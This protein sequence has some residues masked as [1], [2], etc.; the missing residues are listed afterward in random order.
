MLKRRVVILLCL[1]DGVLMRTKKFVP[2]YRY[3]VNLVGNR[4]ADEVVVI[5]VTPAERRAEQRHLFY[6]ALERYAAECFSP[7]TVGGGIRTVE[8]VRQLITL[9]AD[10]VVIGC[11]HLPTL[12]HYIARKFGGQALVAAIN[13]AESEDV[14]FMAHW[15]ASHGA[16]EILLN[17]RPRDG[18][19]LGYDL[20]VLARVRPQVTVPIMVAGGCGTWAHIADAFEAGADAACTSVIHHFTETSLAACKTWLVA[21]CKQP[22]RAAA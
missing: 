10:K 8:E 20:A 2:D 12:G 9:A 4:N 16:G 19:L 18:S 15:W 11:E 17:S 21:N 3:T 22:V 13:H 5:D 14:S 6:G 7:I 1:C